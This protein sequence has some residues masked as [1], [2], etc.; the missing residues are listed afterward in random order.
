MTAPPS[1]AAPQARF[2]FPTLCLM[3]LVGQVGSFLYLP[4]LLVTLLCTT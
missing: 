3:A 4:A 1:V 2:L